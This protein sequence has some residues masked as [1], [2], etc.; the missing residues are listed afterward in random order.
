MIITE[1]DKQ[2][3][4]YCSECKEDLKNGERII[5]TKNLKFFHFFCYKK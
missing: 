2:L 4:D 1:V 3:K 5:L